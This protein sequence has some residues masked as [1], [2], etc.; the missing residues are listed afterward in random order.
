M[1]KDTPNELTTFLETIAKL[2]DP[3]TGCPWDL[4]Q[5][6]QSLSTLLIEE[7][8]EVV[9]AVEYH[10]ESLQEELGDIMCVVGLFAQIASEKNTFSMDS[11]LKGITEKLIRRHPH[12][13]GEL[14]LSSEE[15]VLANW[16]K[17][18]QEER[19][20]DSSVSKKGLLDGLPRSL[21]ALQKAEQIGE[22]VARIGFDWPSATDVVKKIQEELDEFLEELQGK[23]A[24]PSDDSTS[25]EKKERLSE[26]FGD[27]LFSIAQY[28]RHLG[29]SP[30]VALQGAN[31][32]FKRRFNELEMRATNL[33][34]AK[35]LQELSPAQLERLWQ[36]VKSNK[37]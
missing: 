6:F 2:R 29:V 10:P 5:T 12:I 11:I 35:P 18:K 3:E 37:G 30:E 32:K 28:G 19:K 14:K 34:D 1:A 8:Y 25:K 16:E 24:G 36:E 9:D 23:E 21:P 4:K 22:R 26:E 13:F 7:A 20:K 31:E 33:P 15:E 27:F 17:I